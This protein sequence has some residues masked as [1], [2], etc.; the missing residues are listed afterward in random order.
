MIFKLTVL[1]FFVIV[2]PDAFFFVLAGYAYS[3]LK[4]DTKKYVL[5]S[6]LLALIGY[7]ARLLPIQSGIH[8]ILDLIGLMILLIFINKIDV[9]K[10]ITS[11][12]IIFIIIFISEGVM[13]SILTSGF[14][15]DLE[16]IKNDP[17]I[18]IISGIPSFIFI[19]I[20]VGGYYLILSKTGRL[21]NV[22]N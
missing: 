22:S 9:I 2:I 16:L 14:H 19:A 20:I 8:T 6:C 5:S 3:R 7:V 13:F 10:A 18:R 21:K 4:I 12:V 1:E 15:M 17:N 11:A